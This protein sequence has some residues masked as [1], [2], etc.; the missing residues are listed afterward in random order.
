MSIE[1]YSDNCIS[2]NNTPLS[3]HGVAE[4]A[5]ILKKPIEQV[6]NVIHKTVDTFVKPNEE[7]KEKK[8]YKT[9][10]TVGSGVLVLSSLV[11]LLNPKFSGKLLEKVQNLSLKSKNKSK[12][13]SGQKGKFYSYMEELLK[14]PAQFL[15]F[16]VNSIS[17]KDTAFKWFCSEKKEFGFLKK[18]K[19]LQK[20]FQ[21]TDSIN[22]KI[23]DKPHKSITKFFDKISKNT[24]FR[25]YKSVDK[26]IV[27][28]NNMIHAYSEKVPLEVR[29]QIESKLKELEIK[30]EYFSHT[31]VNS[32]LNK[33]EI[34]M[35]DLEG[36]IRARLKMFILGFKN[37]HRGQHFKDNMNFWAKDY[38]QPR[39]NKLEKEGMDFAASIIGNEGKKGSY[40]EIVELLEP[41]LSLEEKKVLETAIEKTKKKIIKANHI[42]NIEYFDK[43]RDLVLGSAPTDILT[44]L[45]GLGASGIAIGSANNNEDRVSRSLTVA[46][47]VIAGFGANLILTAMLTSGFL[48][49]ASGAAVSWVLNRL[50]VK[51]DRAIFP[52]H[53]IDTKPKTDENKNTEVVNV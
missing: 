43:K 3:F 50:G 4:N 9:A 5:A 23:L 30:R 35:C 51:I 32:R 47:P 44:A 31:A 36:Q 16:C 42:E 6:E 39:Q 18:F 19:P 33:Q 28:T 12:T 29:I 1:N 53:N 24:V 45:V 41:H 40:K 8:S 37:P 7:E 20:F 46:F 27:S 15:Q 22:R 17:I 52:E 21:K 11:A 26:N 34:L 48:G 25:K 49:L 10:I 14:T 13:I 38:L 2:K